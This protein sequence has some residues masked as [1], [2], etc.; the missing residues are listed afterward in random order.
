MFGLGFGEILIILVLAL[1]LLG[2]A[3]LPEVAKQLG[4]GLR[5]FKRATDD[6][7]GQFERELYTEDR[8]RSK[9]ALVPPTAAAPVPAPPPGPV[10]AASAD[11]V[12]GLEA[13]VAEPGQVAPEP[14]PSPDAGAGESAPPA[15]PIEAGPAGEAGKLP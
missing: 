3:R 11:N 14:P 10:P 2:P 1:I 4:K 9:P 15:S 13:A 6:L 12:P 8:P 5:D 7:R